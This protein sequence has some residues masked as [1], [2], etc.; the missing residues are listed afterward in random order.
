M[1]VEVG[2]LVNASLSRSTA[3]NHDVKQCAG[4][5]TYV[6]SPYCQFAYAIQAITILGA[7]ARCFATDTRT[8]HRGI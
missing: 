3:V 6:A 8:R 1:K 2:K 5:E 4:G 7:P